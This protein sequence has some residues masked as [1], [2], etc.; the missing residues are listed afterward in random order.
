MAIKGLIGIIGG[1]GFVGSEI[2]AQ[3]IA[4]GYSVKV[5]TRNIDMCRHLKVLPSLSI[6]QINDYQVNTLAAHLKGCEALINLVGILNEKGNDGK[7]FHQVHVGITRLALNACE[8]ANIPRL[9]QM[10]ALN[11]DADAPSHYLR[12][13]GKAENYLKTFAGEEVIYTIFKPS[14]IFGEGDNFLNRFA[15]LLKIVPGIFPLACANARF[16]PVYV[17]DVAKQMIKSIN[18][19]KTYNQSFELCGPNIY[20]LKELVQYTANICGYKRTVLG[21]PKF[22]SK[23]QATVFEY[24]PGK[25][26]SKDNFNSLKLDSVCNQC[27]SCTTPLQAIA[28]T[29]LS[30]N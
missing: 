7:E 14:V 8:Q 18:D 17:G 4:S 29:Y 9:L 30:K 22:L 11:A 21:L 10:S 25:P 24:V 20:S 16:A 2:C 6:I 28:P 12:S 27:A 13:K 15:N 1:S 23:F 19:K 26:F 5:L 3:L